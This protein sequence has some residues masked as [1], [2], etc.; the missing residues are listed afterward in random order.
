MC[1]WSVKRSCP[2]GCAFSFEVEDVKRWFDQQEKDERYDVI[3]PEC[4]KTLNVNP[5]LTVDQMSDVNSLLG[6]ENYPKMSE[7]GR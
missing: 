3:C 1:N 7:F 5:H 6:I 2:C 4:R